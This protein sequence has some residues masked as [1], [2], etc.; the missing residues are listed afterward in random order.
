MLDFIFRARSAQTIA[1]IVCS[2]LVHGL[3]RYVVCGSCS[4]HDMRHCLGMY[5]LALLAA[6]RFPLLWSVFVKYADA[7]GCL[8]HAHAS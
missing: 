7:H 3:T 4:M 6:R 2:C 5:V 8:E 1:K